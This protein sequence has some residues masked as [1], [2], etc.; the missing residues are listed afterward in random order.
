M[1]AFRSVLAL[2]LSLPLMLP[3][4]ALAQGADISF[5]GLRQDGSLPV[6]V[7]ADRLQVDSANGTATFVGNV[8]VAQGDMR[9][10]AGTV[11]VIYA[12]TAGRIAELEASGGVTFVTPDNAAEARE[13]RYDIAAG[14]LV[15]SG[16]VL[17]TQGTTAL[18]ADRMTVDL[19]SG[20][21]RMEGRVRT[22]FQPGGN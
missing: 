1:R 13:A 8:L 5:G 12:E 14:Q 9:L 6:E 7:T 3:L 20:T 16:D 22:V 17:L 19:T 2:V 4:A 11:R 15:L 18:S 21:G 10:S